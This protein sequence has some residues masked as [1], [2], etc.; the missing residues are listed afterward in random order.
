MSNILVRP[1]DLRQIS[2]H[3]LSGSQKVGVA[4]Q[5]VD[6]NILSLIGEKFLGNR[7]ESV[8]THY[9]SKQKAL[10]EAKEIVAH[11]AK[12]L[13]EVAARFEQADQ[14]NI[15]SRSSNE[16]I[17]GVSSNYSFSQWVQESQKWLKNGEKGWELLQ[18]VALWSAL[19]NGDVFTDQVRIFGSE[20][21]SKLE[22]PKNLRSIKAINLMDD[23]AADSISA[24]KASTVFTLIKLTSDVVV[25]MYKYSDVAHRGAAISVDALISAAS[26]GASY[27]GIQVGAM[28]GSA[29]CPGVGTVIGGM[30]GGLLAGSASDILVTDKRII[31]LISPELVQTSIKDTAIEELASFITR[32]GDALGDQIYNSTS[33][34]ESW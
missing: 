15:Q 17:N 29:I 2:D 19:K 12:D 1:H 26:L 14:I 10:L 25:D 5:A 4:L 21:H 8:H 31:G 27:Y 22:L 18:D 16:T 24:T 23:F 28:I 20:W 7:A 32:T 11:F 9:V 13:Q 30:A 6:N 33:R 3:L 34:Q